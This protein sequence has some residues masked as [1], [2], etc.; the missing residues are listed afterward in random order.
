MAR[1]FVFHL[2]DLDVFSWNIDASVGTKSPNR[3]VDVELVQFGYFALSRNTKSNP[4]VKEFA[5]DVNPG[6]PYSGAD[7]DPLTLAILEHQK[8]RGG[9]QDGHVSP[10]TGSTGTYSTFDGPHTFQLL[11]LVNNMRDLLGSDFPRI[12]K[13]ERCPQA[14]REAVAACFD[15]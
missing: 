6:D 1:I 12:D 11:V 15:T 2:K 9:T 5:K 14:L 13:H 3:K 8:Q 10:V 7:N 4:T